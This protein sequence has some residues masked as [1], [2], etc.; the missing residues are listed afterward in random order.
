MTS[1]AANGNDTN[2]TGTEAEVRVVLAAIAYID[3]G[4]PAAYSELT[5]AVLELKAIT[6][7]RREEWLVVAGRASA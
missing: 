5:R 2:G 1:T 4:T 3:E 6:R 7:H